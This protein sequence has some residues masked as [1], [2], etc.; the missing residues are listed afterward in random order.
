ML[1]LSPE[2]KQTVEHSFIRYQAPRIA[3][4]RQ[5]VSREATFISL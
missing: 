3:F 1:I 5:F 2:R 4:Q